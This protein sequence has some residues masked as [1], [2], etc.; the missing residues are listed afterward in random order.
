MVALL[1]WHNP[2]WCVGSPQRWYTGW[3]P[4]AVVAEMHSVD[5]CS[6]WR[7]LLH[8]VAHIPVGSAAVGLAKSMAM[9][10]LPRSRIVPSYRSSAAATC[11]CWNVRRARYIGSGAPFPRPLP[12]LPLRAGISTMLTDVRCCVVL[13]AQ[14]RPVFVRCPPHGLPDKHE[15]ALLCAKTRWQV[16][17]HNPKPARVGAS[18][19][20][21]GA[22]HQV[23]PHVC[24][25]GKIVQRSAAACPV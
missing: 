17:K 20:S 14:L 11:S 5:E 16:H 8:A 18:V 22:V 21:S 10:R 13:I 4:A 9:E 25:K 15:Y 2:A 24:Q 12:P 7:H 6:G 1:Q 19:T 3:P 23:E